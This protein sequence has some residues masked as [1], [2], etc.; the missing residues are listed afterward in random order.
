MNAP[1]RSLSNSSWMTERAGLI[2]RA[3]QCIKRSVVK[4]KRLNTSVKR[5][6]RR[7]NGRPFKCDGSR[8]LRLSHK[9]LLR[10]WYRW[11]IGG[12]V[13]AALRLN[14]HGRPPRVRPAVLLRFVDFCAITRHQ[15]IKAAWLAFAKLPRN[16]GHCR[17]VNLHSVYYYVSAA[18]FHQMQQEL[19]AI[20]AAGVKLGKLRFGLKAGIG[21][22]LAQRHTTKPIEFA[23]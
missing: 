21:Q 16:A 14:F 17:E 10:S 9:T 20:E 7:H 3:C 15:S 19:A 8:T 2:H 11:R 18:G 5:I 12:E 13:A 22:R 6:S 1:H 23:I 4:G